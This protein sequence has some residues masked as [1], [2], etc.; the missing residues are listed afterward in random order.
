MNWKRVDEYIEPTGYVP[1]TIADKLKRTQEELGRHGKMA[2]ARTIKASVLW[3]AFGAA[4]GMVGMVYFEQPKPQP[5][6][7]HSEMSYATPA[8]DAA[9]DKLKT[10]LEVH[11]IQQE[12]LLRKVQ[13]D[14]VKLST[15]N[16]ARSAQLIERE[17]VKSVEQDGQ[18][19]RV[20][21]GLERSSGDYPASKPVTQDASP[22]SIQHMA[23]DL[24]VTHMVVK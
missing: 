11:F 7:V 12:A 20:G 8:L 2:M 16:K 24:G 14:T 18:L 22:L 17:S 21:K 6:V 3:C 13:Q 5:V 1:E 4:L 19:V 15:I 9:L 10:S 23:K